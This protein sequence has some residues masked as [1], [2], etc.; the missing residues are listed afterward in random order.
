[1]SEEEAS[2]PTLDNGEAD[3]SDSASA[4]RG[5]GRGRGGRG[6]SRGGRGSGRGG[7]G[8][9]RGRGGASAGDDNH[10]TP[11]DAT[12]TEGADDGTSAEATDDSGRGRGRGRGRGGRGGDGRGRGG[13]PRVYRPLR[14]V[15]QPDES[16]WS[17]ASAAH[18]STLSSVNSSIES[19]TSKIEGSVKTRKA[20]REELKKA[21]AV[22]DALTASKAELFV[23][24]NKL[25]D[26]IASVESSSIS[27]KR[28]LD[29][30]KKEL[31]FL[32][33]A[34]LDAAV[35]AAEKALN[36]RTL[37]L[38]EERARL[39]EVKKLR[40]MRPRVVEYER[41]TKA[42]GSS[43]E[44][45]EQLV[46]QREE[47]HKAAYEK[48][49]EEEKQRRVVEEQ[50]KKEKALTADI[51]GWIAK[52]RELITKR[53]QEER[54][55]LVKEDEHARALR[56]YESYAKEKAWR[57]GEEERRAK[58]KADYEQR[59]ARREQRELDRQQRDEEERAWREE[60]DREEAEKDP[61]EHE[62]SVVQELLKY[63]HKLSDKRAEEDGEDE[64][65]DEKEK[66]LQL[67]N[68]RV[69]AFGGK[70]A[71]PVAK[72]KKGGG[73]SLF[74]EL[75]QPKQ[76]KKVKAKKANRPLTHVPDVFAQFSEV[77]VEA[78]LM[79]ADLDSTLDKL[80]AREQYY[81]TAPRPTKKGGGK[82]R[83][84]GEQAAAEPATNATAG[85][86][87][88]AED[89]AEEDEEVQ[90]T[91]QPQLADTE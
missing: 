73:E 83:R 30:A 1:M 28:D 10:A 87:P 77:D 47:A 3:T 46:A 15:P 53:Q 36:S 66:Q 91:T 50:G 64:D 81:D 22:L 70:A 6:D 14:E 19:F 40:A 49:E 2:A 41:Q 67:V 45:V 32:S 54:Q 17:A 35:K 38:A 79:S 34:D 29:T 48:K 71:K 62:K 18:T 76:A 85:E 72:A 78:P 5:R 7:R 68:D 75:V 39:E 11:D 33:T 16:A 90:I 42:S 27:R 23:T 26:H 12:P 21:Q 82:Q 13:G 86:E 52:R 4:D 51:D 60:R 58:E 74:S 80:K 9:G 65:A 43:S 37:V 89:E 8:R 20:V 61:W 25:K 88:A 55:W 56:E 31:E 57:E 44:D 63:T 24:Y 69:A 59:Q 84:G